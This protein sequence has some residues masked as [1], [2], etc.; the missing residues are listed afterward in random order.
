MTT[1]NTSPV[2]PTTTNTDDLPTYTVCFRRGNF[3]EV[4]RMWSMKEAFDT[5]TRLRDMGYQAQ[6]WEA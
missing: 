2:L 4:R 5:V 3:V 1:N 6:C